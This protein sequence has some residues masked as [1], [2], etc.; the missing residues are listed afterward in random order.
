MQFNPK[1][2]TIYYMSCRAISQW[3]VSNH[4]FTHLWNDIY[5]NLVVKSVGLNIFSLLGSS[6]SSSVDAISFG[7]TV[8]LSLHLKLNFVISSLI[9]GTF[10]SICKTLLDIYHGAFTIARRALFW[11]LYNITMFELLAKWTCCNFL[12]EE[13][14]DGV[15]VW[16][17]SVC[18]TSREFHYLRRPRNFH[19]DIL[20]VYHSVVYHLRFLYK[21][22]TALQYAHGYPFC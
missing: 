21:Y 7:Y 3:I 14:E 17:L 16:G 2:Y 18:L 20:C 13:T 22:I 11:Y 6:S 5:K 19:W 8:I 9:V 15:G 10:K 4:M 12:P 1:S